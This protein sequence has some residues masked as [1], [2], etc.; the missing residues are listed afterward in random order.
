MALPSRPSIRVGLPSNPSPRSR[1]LNA[2]AAPDVPSRPP[3]AATDRSYNHNRAESSPLPASQLRPQRSLTNLPSQAARNESRGRAPR[4]NAPAPAPPVPRLPL[5]L[6]KPK[7]ER[8]YGNHTGATSA[9][10]V[11]SASSEGDS[12]FTNPWPSSASS[13]ATSVEDIGE[14]EVPEPVETKVAPGFGSSLWS[15]VA[16]AAG[17]LTVNVSRAWE[18]NITRYSGEVTPPGE[19][20]RLARAM[21]AYHIGKARHPSDLPEWLFDERDRGVRS[22]AVDDSTSNEPLIERASAPKPLPTFPSRVTSPAPD[23]NPRAAYTRRDGDAESTA[24][25]SRAAQ[26][27]R[28]MRDAKATRTP[29]IRFVDNVHPRHAGRGRQTMEEPAPP[30]AIPPLPTTNTPPATPRAVGRRPTAVGLPSSVRPRR[31]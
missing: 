17:S 22:R 31:T 9:S 28:E 1:S 10:S 23:N 14:K 13:A 2:R 4:L 15:R 11:S 29:T 6:A 5:N 3:S 26:R 12:F 8:L 24:T 21:K 7:A 27:L 16:E 30:M 20:S 19:E 18:V 25:M